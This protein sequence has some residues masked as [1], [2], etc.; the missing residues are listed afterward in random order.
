MWNVRETATQA[1]LLHCIE[2]RGRHAI[3]GGCRACR[4]RVVR[5]GL[6]LS[7]VSGPEDS[8]T[9]RARRRMITR[10]AW[11][12]RDEKPEYYHDCQIADV[13]T[14]GLWGLPVLANKRG[15]GCGRDG[16]AGPLVARLRCPHMA[17]MADMASR[18]LAGA[19][20]WARQKPHPLTAGQRVR[21][22]GATVAVET[23]RSSVL[24]EL[25]W[26]LG[27]AVRP[28]DMTQRGA[29]LVKRLAASFAHK[30][31]GTGEGRRA[32]LGNAVWSEA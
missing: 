27:R 22:G 11:T 19:R 20:N 24:W 8:G 17:D 3:G 28:S 12:T 10:A 26:C 9:T 2:E 18:R 16:L 13:S 6:T 21:R 15:T 25:R 29:V 14:F 30:R 4:R 7:H 5:A 32:G 23:G 31:M 1:T